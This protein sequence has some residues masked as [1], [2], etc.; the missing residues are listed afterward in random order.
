MRRR[1]LHIWM[2]MCLVALVAT[3]S[4]WW[5]RTTVV[6]RYRV[7]MNRDGLTEAVRKEY[8]DGRVVTEPRRR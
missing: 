4:A 7:D 8:A 5:L 1:R 2:L 6:G 3:V